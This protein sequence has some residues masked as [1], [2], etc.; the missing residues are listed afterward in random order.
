MI[1]QRARAAGFQ[2][3]TG[4]TRG[5]GLT[6]GFVLAALGPTLGSAQ[7]SRDGSIAGI[8]A[9]FVDVNGI[10]TRHRAARLSWIALSSR[11]GMFN[12][13]CFQRG[14]Q[15]KCCGDFADTFCSTD[16]SKAN[17]RML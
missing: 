12:L 7:V 9:N 4:R 11:P 14:Q 1:R 8:E 5:L 6:V 10:R 15:R 17:R 2:I 13:S 3:A 16:C